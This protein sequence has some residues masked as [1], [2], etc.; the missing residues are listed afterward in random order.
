MILLAGRRRPKA[1]FGATTRGSF[2]STPRH[3]TSRSKGE[4]KTNIR[5]YPY[6][7]L[8]RRHT[9]SPGENCPGRISV[10]PRPLPSRP[11]IARKPVTHQG[12]TLLRSD[13]GYPWDEVRECLQQWLTNEHKVRLAYSQQLIVERK[14]DKPK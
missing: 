1:P 9:P 13:D 3:S 11:C 5:L 10:K 7:Q 4:K 8:V 14:A 2:F 6:T 12:S